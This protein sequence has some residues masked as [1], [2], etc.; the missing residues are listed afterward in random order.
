MFTEQE[1]GTQ[2]VLVNSQVLRGHFRNGS[3]DYSQIPVFSFIKNKLHQCS[4]KI[5]SIILKKVLFGT[6]N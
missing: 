3:V 4:V 5:E 2:N 6:V 1:R